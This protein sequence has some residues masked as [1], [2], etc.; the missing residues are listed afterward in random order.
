MGKWL[1]EGNPTVLL[2]DIAS[3]SWNLNAWKQELY[4]KAQIGI[5]HL[6]KTSNASLNELSNLKTLKLKPKFL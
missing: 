2:F 1:V 4:E 6:G 5:P 3:A